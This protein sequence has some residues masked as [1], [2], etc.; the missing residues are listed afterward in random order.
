MIYDEKTTE[1]EISPKLAGV[2]VSKPVMPVVE[3][4]VLAPAVVLAAGVPQS[5]LTETAHSYRK[6]SAALALSR[7]KKKASFEWL[8][9]TEMAEPWL[10]RLIA[11]LTI[12][13]LSI[14]VL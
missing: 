10:L 3:P 6:Q 13:L 1:I 9:Q 14:L 12:L 5:S 4:Q 7:L 2:A 8:S 11:V